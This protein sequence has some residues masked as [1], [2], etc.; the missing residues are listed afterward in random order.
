VACM[1]SGLRGCRRTYYSILKRAW[2]SNFK[3]VC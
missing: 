2:S 1:S 3:M